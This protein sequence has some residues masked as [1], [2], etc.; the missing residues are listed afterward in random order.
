MLIENFDN[1]PITG[2]TLTLK[3]VYSRGSAEEYL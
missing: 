3:K 1:I 2:S